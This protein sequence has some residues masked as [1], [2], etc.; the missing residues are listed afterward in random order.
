M[1]QVLG[2]IRQDGCTVYSPRLQL[3]A[4]RERGW[5]WSEESTWVA[6]MPLTIW[7][8]KQKH[9]CSTISHDVTTKGDD[10]PLDCLWAPVYTEHAYILVHNIHVYVCM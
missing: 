2:A 3:E 5:A 8:G 9:D 4:D 6:G 10:R 7:P 1:Q